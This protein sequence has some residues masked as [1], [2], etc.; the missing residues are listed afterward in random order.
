MMSCRRMQH[1]TRSFRCH[2]SPQSSLRVSESLVHSATTDWL[3][4]KDSDNL[5]DGKH[6]N[7]RRVEKLLQGIPIGEKVYTRHSS[8][9]YRQIYLDKF[10]ILQN[11]LDE[12]KNNDFSASIQSLASTLTSDITKQLETTKASDPNYDTTLK[13]AVA[14]IENLR[15][16]ATDNHLH[17]AFMM[18]YYVARYQVRTWYNQYTTGSTNI[19][20]AMS[21]KSMIGVIGLLEDNKTNLKGDNLTQAYAKFIMNFQMSGVL[22]L[23]IDLEPTEHSWMTYS[24]RP[25]KHFMTNTKTVRIRLWCCKHKM[26][27]SWQYTTI[28]AGRSSS[29]SQKLAEYLVLSEAGTALWLG[30]Q[31]SWRL[32]I[33]IKS[34][35][36]MGQ[37][38]LVCSSLH[39]P[40]ILGVT[41]WKWDKM[42]GA[43]RIK[44]IRWA[45][46]VFWCL[47]NRRLRLLNAR[48]SSW[49]HSRTLAAAIAF[50]VL[51]VS[52][53]ITRLAY[54]WEDISG[55]WTCFKV[56]AGFEG[57]ID[58]VTGSATKVC[59]QLAMKACPWAHSME[60]SN[61]FAAWFTRTAAQTEELAVESF[62]RIQKLIGRN[63]SEALG[64]VLGWVTSYKYA[65]RYWKHTASSSGYIRS[66]QSRKISKTR[67][68]HYWKL[69]TLSCWYRHRCKFL[70]SLQDG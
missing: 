2:W 32:S 1:S 18:Y 36:G 35:V 45:F 6:E 30:G 9:L 39:F 26:R 51:G 13:N 54:F 57:R 56:C 7:G 20:L 21:I 48:I 24:K 3:C 65:L 62:S 14:E 63:F 10:P 25:C 50:I 27:S 60:I 55:V 42:V 8:K 5:D 67:K 68:T 29:H 23:L 49:W 37:S 22:P 17:W 38:T 40:V 44:A 19:S 59:T 33:G 12:Q 64:N 4:W 46:T 11:F 47:I 43:E 66:I 70:P 58:K 52:V 28:S 31:N 61:A 15:V 41:I 53:G 16:W 34:L 69:T